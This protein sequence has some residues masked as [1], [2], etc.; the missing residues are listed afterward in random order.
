MYEAAV[1]GGIPIIMP[2]KQSLF[3]NTIKKIAGIMNGT[4]NYILTKMESEGS[5]FN[6]VLK[7]AQELWLCRNRSKRRYSGTRC[8]KQNI[9]TRFTGI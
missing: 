4:T 8:S 5:E 2:L 6:T 1:A 3:G 9:H 7:E